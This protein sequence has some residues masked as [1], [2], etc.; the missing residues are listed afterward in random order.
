[1]NTYPEL[2]GRQ[3]MSASVALRQRLQQRLGLLKIGGV[4]TFRKPAI[5]RRQEFA[6]FGLLTL[7]L[8]EATQTHRGAQL[9]RFRLLATGHVE[10][11]LQPGFC[12]CLWRPRLP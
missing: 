11:P 3:G 1:M 12:L 8:P 7:L 2:E 6:R 5:D 9:Q 10:S 4:K